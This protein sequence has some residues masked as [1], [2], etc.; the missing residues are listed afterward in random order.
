MA[1]AAR[2]TAGG[3]ALGVTDLKDAEEA[4]R[5]AREQLDAA[6]EAAEAGTWTYDVLNDLLV[7]DGILARRYG[8]PPEI[9]SR[10]ISL[11]DTITLCHPDDQERVRRS[12]AEV[13]REG[14]R[15]ESEHRGFEVDGAY[16]WIIA[17]G[18]VERDE[19]GVA[20]RMKASSSTSPAAARPKRSCGRAWSGNGRRRPS[21][22]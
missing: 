14:T 12:F 3:G 16:H 20:V 7:P 1:R 22:P 8:I 4:L 13:F 10:G 6:L 21:S 17:R 18:K 5:E 11:E 2:S 19:H 15:W 9:A